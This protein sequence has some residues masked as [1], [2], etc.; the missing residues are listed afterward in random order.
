MALR[1]HARIFFENL[2]TNFWPMYCIH[3]TN[4]DKIYALWKYSVKMA[5]FMLLVSSRWS[6]MLKD[7]KS[8]SILHAMGSFKSSM[9]L[10]MVDTALSRLH[11]RFVRLLL[12][13]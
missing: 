4:T 10:P 9:Y 1:R 11:F 8:A 6:C 7:P 3:A 2:Q 13:L 5:F 12:M